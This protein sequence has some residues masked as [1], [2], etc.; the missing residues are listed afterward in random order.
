MIKSDDEEI[1]TN[2]IKEFKNHKKLDHK[3]IVKVFELYIDKTI[4]T[5]YTIMEIV[6]CKEMFDVISKLSIFLI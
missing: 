2:I 5:I 3:N 6:E 1:I 4:C